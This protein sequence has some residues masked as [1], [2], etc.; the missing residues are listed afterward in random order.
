MATIPG[1]AGLPLLGDRSYDFYKDPVKF[2]EK[3]I[4]VYKNRNFIARFLNK[5]TVFVGCNNTLNCLLKEEADNLDLGYK[6]FMADI[7]GDNILFT[8]GVDMV[9]LRESLSLLF[10][11]D[12][13]QSYQ[14]TINHVVK[15]FTDKINTQKPVCLYETLK[16]VCIEV[17]L[18]LFLGIDFDTTADLTETIVS[19]TTT[20]WHGIISVPVNLKLP[21][22]GASTFSKALDAKAQLLDIIER[23]KVNTGHRHFPRKIQE[24][25]KGDNKVFVNNHL[26]LFTSAL[27]PK[28]LSSLLTSFMIEISKQQDLQEKVLSDE[29][30]RDMFML[31]VQRMYPPFF[32]GRRMVNKELVINGERFPKGH[33]IVFSTYATHRDPE[34]FEDPHE[35]QPQR[36]IEKNANDKD[37]LFCFGAGPRCCIGQR[38]VWCIINTIIDEVLTKYKVTLLEEQDL[39]HKWLPV[40]RPKNQVLVQFSQREPVEDKT[41]QTSFME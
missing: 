35:F 5:A 39:T 37:R 28:A 23:R 21:V 14:Q 11:A 19:L 38:L 9:S 25:P 41:E 16:R 29:H 15:K 12:A 7:Y 24:V 36:W 4:S 18:S 30:L 32:G 6:M 13:I 26:L 22:G 8:D 1:S 33:A 40:S 34:I 20:H 31:E 17:C 2:M 27:V 3:N 10:T